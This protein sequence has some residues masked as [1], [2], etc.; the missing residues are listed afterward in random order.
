[1]RLTFDDG[2]SLHTLDVLEI[3]EA[4]EVRGTF[5]LV[6]KNV[7]AHPEIARAIAAAGHAIGNHSQTH[8]RLSQLPD[9]EIREELERCNAALEAA[10]LPHPTLFRPPY[11]ATDDRVVAIAADLGMEQVLWDVDPEDWREAATPEGVARHVG[12]N[13]GD[14]SRVLVHDGRGDRSTTVAALRLLLEQ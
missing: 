12:E 3:L 10:G 7:E 13:A 1:M 2:P 11:G 9:D 5:F 8:G 6:G 4:A 14:D